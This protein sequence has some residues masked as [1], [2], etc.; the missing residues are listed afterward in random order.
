MSLPLPRVLMVEDSA[1]LTAVYRAYLQSEPV[2]LV[3][4]SSGQ[5]A[6][7]RL[8]ELAVDVVLCDIRMPGMDGI[9][10]ALHLTRLPRPPAVIFTTAYDNFAVQAFELNALDYLI[11]SFDSD[12]ITIDYRVRG[13]TREMDGR[14]CYLD[15]KIA[16]IQDFI[17]AKTLQEYDAQDINV[18]QSNIFHTKMLIKEL[19]LQN[20]LFNNDV[21]EF[22]PKERLEITN[23][24]RREMIEIYTG[25]NVYE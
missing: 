23:R 11:G 14:K 10:L 2:E 1:S 19:H 8:R 12:I 25:M 20:Y 24:L 15:H 4:V 3:C 9:E 13:F 22:S 18:Y 21:L 5:A 7:D 17:D 16:S 6:L